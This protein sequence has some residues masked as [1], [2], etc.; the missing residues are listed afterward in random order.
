MDFLSFYTN[1]ETFWTA[2]GKP[3]FIT[4]P[5]IT[6]WIIMLIDNIFSNIEKVL[7]NEWISRHGFCRWTDHGSFF[8]DSLFLSGLELSH[9][10]FW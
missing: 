5:N 2:M 7:D 9:H 4:I 8:N 3:T 1:N 10:E 6:G